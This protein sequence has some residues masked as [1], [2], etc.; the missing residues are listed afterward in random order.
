MATGGVKVQTRIARWR[1][2]SSRRWALRTAAAVLVVG[3]GLTGAL[4]MQDDEQADPRLER[5]RE[6]RER[7]SVQPHPNAGPALY[8]DLQTLPLRDLQFDRLEDETPI[9][10]FTVEI[11]NAGEGRVELSAPT[12]NDTGETVA[13]YQNLYD[14]AV[15]GRLAEQRPVDGRIVYH[16]AHGH[17]HF[18]DFARYDLL[19]CNESGGCQPIG[20]GAKVSFCLVDSELEDF[21]VP[22]PR[23]Y[24]TCESMLQ[25]LTPGYSDLYAWDL[26]EQWVVLPEG[27][28]ADGEYAVRVTA[29][30]DNRLDEAA[31]ERE[32]NNAAT[33]Y[34]TVANG[35]IENVREVP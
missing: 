30:P 5:Q 32:T 6:R 31:D 7:R 34:F 17:Y 23:Q 29:D 14:A 1:V 8:P 25:G 10:R 28:L 2:A 35:E 13:L 16:D 9:L 33:A 18:A 4:A 26:P 19:D 22:Y 21:G 15:G 12:A 3:G 27:P 24:T 20:L 11:W